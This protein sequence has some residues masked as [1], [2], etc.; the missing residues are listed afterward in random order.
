M[1]YLTVLAAMLAVPSAT[2]AVEINL[3]SYSCADFVADVKDPADGE[4]LLR[5]LMMIS[6]STGYAAAYQQKN[7]RADPAAL[8]LVAAMLGGVC[9]KTPTRTVI[10]AMVETI[11]ELAKGDA[12]I[13]IPAPAPPAASMSRSAPIRKGAFS[14]Y[15]NYDSA[16]GDLRKMQR[17]SEEACIKACGGERA[18]KAFSYDKWDKWCFLK[19]EV[20]ALVLDPGSLTGVRGTER[21]PQVSDVQVRIDPRSA[22][23]FSG[24]QIGAETKVPLDACEST[25]QQDGSCL[26]YTFFKKE[27]SCQLFSSIDSFSRDQNAASGVKTQQAP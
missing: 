22:R 21:D 14:L 8:R 19:S 20:K 9:A 3:Q 12:K 27:G 17:V 7:T 16:G 23:K 18:C 10:Q 11:S 6:W 15:D 13:A 26:G 5:S 25:C 2:R 1:K 24:Q 4:K